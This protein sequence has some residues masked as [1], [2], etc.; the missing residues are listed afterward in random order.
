MN[1][2]FL[3]E[4]R[5]K[6]QE[7]R[8]SSFQEELDSDLLECFAAKAEAEGLSIDELFELAVLEKLGLSYAALELAS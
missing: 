4:H 3:M 6:L 7:S 8:T 1:K 5:Q 2:T